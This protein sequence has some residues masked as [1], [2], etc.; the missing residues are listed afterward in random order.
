MK[1][2][3]MIQLSCMHACITFALNGLVGSIYLLMIEPLLALA[4]LRCSEKKC[5]T[6]LISRSLNAK[7]LSKISPIRKM[8]H[9]MQGH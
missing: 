1:A 5:A 2:L 9:Y 8:L 6:E 7:P 3:D 4:V